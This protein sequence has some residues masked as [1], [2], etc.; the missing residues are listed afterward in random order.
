MLIA[1]FDADGKIMGIELVG[2]RAKT[3]SEKMK[4][5]YGRVND[6]LP[7]VQYSCYIAANA[8]R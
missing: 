3:L 4:L 6:P 8:P 5:T 7:R 2:R 1:D